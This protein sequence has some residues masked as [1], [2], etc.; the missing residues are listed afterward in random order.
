VF[1]VV[2]ERDQPP[3]AGMEATTRRGVERRSIEVEI[4]ILN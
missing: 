4:C 2:V 3:F 1:A